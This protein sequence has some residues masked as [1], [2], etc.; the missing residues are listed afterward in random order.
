MNIFYNLH[1]L[2]FTGLGELYILLKYKSAM[3]HAVCI[4]LQ[5]ALQFYIITQALR[6]YHCPM[7]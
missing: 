5:V 7:Y 1:N 6:N 3:Y 2:Q 4:Q